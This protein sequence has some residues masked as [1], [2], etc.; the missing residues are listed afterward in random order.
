MTEPVRTAAKP[1]PKKAPSGKPKLIRRRPQR[2]TLR[3]SPYAWAK[4][5]FLRDAGPTEIGGFGISAPGQPLLVEDVRLVTQRCDWASVDFQDTAVADYFDEQVDRGRR[6]EEFGRIWVHTHP[7]ASPAPSATDEETF[8]RVFGACDW[9]VMFILAAGGASYA[10]LQFGVGPG[11]SMEIPV[12][13]DYGAEF[14]ASARDAW[15]EEYATCVSP[16]ESPVTA[17]DLDDRVGL[18]EFAGVAAGDGGCGFA[19]LL[20]LEEADY[21]QC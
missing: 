8:R 10:R 3:L 14:E 20:G 7:G 21:D 6:P 18:A 16:I 13:L 1:R 12:E 15:Q 4:L 19:D 11:G 17:W 2:P 9:A 5:L